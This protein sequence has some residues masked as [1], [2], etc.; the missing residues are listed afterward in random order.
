MSSFTI[1]VDSN[2]DLPPEF[3]RENEIEVI[4]MPF[5]IDGTPHK[6]GYWQMISAS[7]FY[8]A[9][10][11]GSVAKTSQINPQTYV[12]IFTEYAKQ[13]K[14][15]IFLVLSSGLSSTYQSA[16]LAL[17][18]IKETYPDCNIFAIDSLNASSGHGLLA[19]LTV[20]KR[21]EGL[22]AG[23]TAAWLE[24]QKN[25]LVGLFMVDNLMYLH[26]GGRLSKL[27]AITGSV[28]NI[29]PVLNFA[30]DGTL[31]LKERV[32]GRKAAM[33]MMVKQLK[34]SI[35]PDTVLETITVS[36]TDCLEDAETFAEMIRKSVNVNNV[37]ITMMGPV[38]GAHLG[39][40]SVTLVFEADMT[41]SEYEAR[42]YKA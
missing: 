5:E 13:E 4:P 22:T 38:I 35:S 40:G 11:N 14:D 31:C 27:S 21:N 3:I 9:L 15:A 25:R 33:E 20:R 12:E 18:E 39:P 42:F 6:L 26:R 28:L 7:D 1:V 23:E 34:R 37:V 24:N 19:E 29:K 41:R 36:H 17:A 30:P 8:N 32:R 16:V 2:C 10:R